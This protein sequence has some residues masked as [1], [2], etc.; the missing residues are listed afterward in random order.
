[1]KNVSL[2]CTGIIVLKQELNMPQTRRLLVATAD[3][4]ISSFW[5]GAQESAVGTVC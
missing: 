2:T 1:M 4:L 3:P 5:V